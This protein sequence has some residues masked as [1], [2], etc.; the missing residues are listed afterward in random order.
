MI[1]IL[2]PGVTSP[3]I[4]TIYKASCSKC[5]CE[6]EFDIED[7]H[8]FAPSGN[9]SIKCPQCGHLIKNKRNAFNSREVKINAL[10]G[11][12]VS[13]TN[14]GYAFDI[15]FN[16]LN[17]SVYTTRHNDTGFELAV[18]EKNDMFS[19]A[20]A[21]ITEDEYLIIKPVIDRLENK[22]GNI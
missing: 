9:M 19:S 8:D 16:K 12:S 4:K 11:E 3:I 6:F 10:C 14:N 21:E 13:V 1:N 5:G 20:F 2:K 7:T 15:L 18:K 22:D 17:I